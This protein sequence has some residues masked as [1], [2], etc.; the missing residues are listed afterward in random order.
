MNVVDCIVLGAVSGEL[1]EVRRRMEPVQEIPNFPWSAFLGRIGTQA[2]VAVE[3]GIGLVNAGASLAAALS[4]FSARAV[5]MVGCGGAL[6]GAG[7]EP[8]DLVSA[9]EEIFGDLGIQTRSRRMDFER[10]GIPLIRKSTREIYS[11]IPLDSDLFPDA[12]SR[13]HPFLPP[14]I[15][16]HRGPFV[17]V[18]S[19]SG[20]VWTARATARRSSACLE[21]MEGAGAALVAL[22]FGIPFLEFRGVSNRAGDRNKR[23]WDMAGAAAVSQKA[24]L[25]FLEGG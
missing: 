2:V 3:T 14:G 9:T 10:I 19:V 16:I 13:I 12:E 22:R 18:S 23:R 21:N 6:P 5:L 1:E 20:D 4:R 24:A 15:R 25:G 7:L 17:T 8:G 11:R